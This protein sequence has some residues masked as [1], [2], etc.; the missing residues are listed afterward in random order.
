MRFGERRRNAL[1]GC[2]LL[3]VLSHGHGDRKTGRGV[4]VA[5]ENVGDGV[6]DLNQAS[7]GAN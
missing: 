4:D 7:I 6:A 5:E 2:E 3:V 1:G